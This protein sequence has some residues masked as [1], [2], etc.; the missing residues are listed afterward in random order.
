[1]ARKGRMG[2]HKAKSSFNKRSLIA[3]CHTLVILS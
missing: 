3:A 2:K 1:M